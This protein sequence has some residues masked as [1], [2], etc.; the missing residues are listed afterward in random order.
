MEAILIARERTVL[1]ENAFHEIV[2]WHVPSPVP[3]SS[4]SFKYRL[5]LVVGGKCIL[6]YDNERGKGDHR[7]IGDREEPFEFTTLEALL[8]AFERDMERMLV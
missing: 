7:H 5:A 4:H 3:G 8:T 6:R 1:S 2:V